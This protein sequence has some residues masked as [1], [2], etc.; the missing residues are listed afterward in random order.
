MI[1]DKV[2]M[3]DN[4]YV[5]KANKGKIFTVISEPWNCC[6]TMI[7]KLNGISGG[8]AVDGLTIV[9]EAEKALKEREKNA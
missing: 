9:E 2:V 6:G 3:N 5:S 8:Y 1:G 7:V 4:Y